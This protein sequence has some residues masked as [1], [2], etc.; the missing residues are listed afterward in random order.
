[1]VS[2]SVSRTPSVPKPGIVVEDWHTS[3]HKC[4]GEQNGLR[5]GGNQSRGRDGGWVQRPDRQVRQ[6]DGD[7]CIGGSPR[8]DA[9]AA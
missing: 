8:K 7:G 3:S 4:A 1:M 5:R 2:G 6:A 9:Q